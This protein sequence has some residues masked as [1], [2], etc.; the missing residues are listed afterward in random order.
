L[1]GA[2]RDAALAT[3]APLATPPARVVSP[4]ELRRLAAQP[5]IDIGAH[6]VSH[7]CLAALPPHAQQLEIAGSRE[8]LEAWLGAPPRAFAYP[9]GTRRDFDDHCVRCTREA[10]FTHACANFP[11]RVRPDCDPFRLPR[12][13][14]RDWDV[15]N[16][17]AHVE[18][19][20]GAR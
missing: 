7:A 4:D 3:M 19:Q 18:V 8:Q 20:R 6:T 1:R 15:E 12:M 10:G 5:G 17:A 13:I 14:V 9:F 11:G 2:D 16:F